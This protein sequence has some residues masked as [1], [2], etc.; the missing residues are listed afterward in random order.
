MGHR[1][2][3]LI[4]ITLSTILFCTRYI[5]AA[6]FGSNTEVWDADLFQ[7]LLTYVDGGTLFNLSIISLII[8]IVYLV[9]AEISFT[10]KES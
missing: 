7:Y 3:G 2:A 6:I 4:F 5:A 1:G 10:R 9:M 8:G